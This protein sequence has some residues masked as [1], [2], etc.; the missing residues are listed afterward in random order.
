MLRIVHIA[1]TLGCIIHVCGECTK[2]TAPHPDTWPHHWPLQQSRQ[3]TPPHPPADRRPKVSNSP[4]ARLA[5]G[6]KDPAPR[7]AGQ[8]FH[9]RRAGLAPASPRREAASFLSGPTGCAVGLERAGRSR[10]QGAAPCARPQTDLLTP[11]TIPGGQSPAPCTY[12]MTCT[13]TGTSPSR[14]TPQVED[15]EPVRRTT[16]LLSRRRT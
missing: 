7:N 8:G 5:S 12:C 4:P 2:L 3:P 14:R 9:R 6:M 10:R 16:S 15:S 13:A 1:V 11:C